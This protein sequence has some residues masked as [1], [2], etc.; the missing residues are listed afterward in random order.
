[1]ERWKGSWMWGVAAGAGLA[2]VMVAV[3]LSAKGPGT[4]VAFADTTTPT[5][6]TATSTATPVTPT[7]TPTVPCDLSITKHA[8]DTSPA[9]NGIVN[10]TITVTDNS[11]SCNHDIEVDDAIPDNMDCQDASVDSGS[12]VPTDDVDINSGCDNNGT[13]RW[14]DNVSDGNMGNGDQLILDLSLKVTSDASAGDDI[15]NK[16]CITE[17]EGDSVDICV[18]RTVTVASETATPTTVPTSA[19]PTVAIPTARPVTPAPVYVPPAVAPSVSVPSTGT[20][21][22]GGGTSP[23]ALPLGLLGGALLLTSG[24]VFVKRTR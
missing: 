4:G 12:D 6:P 15:K 24:V 3:M 11:G 16:A 22:S 8:D 1:M 2:L 17:E 14:T 10:Y 9:I 7:A 23:W 20:G 13:V 5:P 21:P 19:V 18:S